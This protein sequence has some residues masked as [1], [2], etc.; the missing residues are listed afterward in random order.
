[1]AEGNHPLDKVRQLQR[2]LYLA[3]KRSAQRRFHALYDRIAR[4][5]V[6]ERAWQQVRNNRGAAGIDGQTTSRRCCPDPRHFA[7][8]LLHALT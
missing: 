3:A 1:M 4:R 5:D 8:P 7:V 2:Q 6:L